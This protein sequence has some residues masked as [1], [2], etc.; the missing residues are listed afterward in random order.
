MGVHRS[1]ISQVATHT[2]T[3]LGFRIV[4]GVR[5]NK[6]LLKQILEQEERG[7]TERGA[8]TRITPHQAPH[9]A[10]PSIRNEFAAAAYRMHGQVKVISLFHFYLDYT[11]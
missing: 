5:V 11:E 2:H 7:E 10:E 8:G 4:V 9:E 1:Y 6:K 3:C